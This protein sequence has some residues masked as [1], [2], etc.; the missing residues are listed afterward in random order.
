ML[1]IFTASFTRRNN[2]DGIETPSKTITKRHIR[3][4]KLLDLP[5]GAL[6]RFV[7][8]LIGPI[9]ILRK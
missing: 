7:R 4:G 9:V 3:T 5:S 8:P 1:K 2:G 6:E